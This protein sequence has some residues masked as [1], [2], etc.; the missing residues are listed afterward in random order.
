[1]VDIQNLPQYYTPTPMAMLGAVGAPQRR[2][3]MAP[4]CRSAGSPC[5]PLLCLSAHSQGLATDVCISPRASG[6]CWMRRVPNKPS[7]TWRGCTERGALLAHPY[8]GGGCTAVTSPPS[9]SPRHEFT[10]V[11]YFC[12]RQYGRTQRGIQFF[13]MAESNLG[14]GL[15]LREV[16][17]YLCSWLSCFYP[18]DRGAS[19]AQLR[20]PRAERGLPL[21]RHLAATRQTIAGRAASS[22]SAAP[23]PPGLGVAVGHGRGEPCRAE[24]CRTA[25]SVGA[26]A[27]NFTG[28]FRAVRAHPHGADA[29]R[30]SSANARNATR[31]CRL[32]DGRAAGS[33]R[34]GIAPRAVEAS[35]TPVRRAPH[36][37]G[38]DPR[39]PTWGRGRGRALPDR[40][41]RGW[42]GKRSP[43]SVEGLVRPLP[44]HPSGMVERVAIMPRHSGCPA[45]PALISGP[46]TPLISPCA[47]RK[48]N[49][50]QHVSAAPAHKAPGL[51][52]SGGQ[53]GPSISAPG[54]LCP[55][56][57]CHTF[58]SRIQ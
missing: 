35:R 50:T 36:G 30:F 22:S 15:P 21:P 28:S 24:P 48:G 53:S 4:L 49:K 46:R 58:C 17:T 33:T 47:Q 13:P 43:G 11:P 3:C 20:R 51:G 5:A 38:T 12:K 37:S 39:A 16:V 23:E 45:R 9:R 34:C 57:P 14:A 54:P 32:R 56:P 8:S 44:L 40:T 42:G 6:C 31:L 52:L 25:P 18:R 26:A 1:M 55:S 29:Q 19:T 27:E 41:G 2:C 7:L 10:H